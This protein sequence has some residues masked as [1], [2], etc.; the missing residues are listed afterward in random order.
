MTTTPPFGV[1]AGSARYAP[2][3]NPSEAV[4]LIDL[5]IYGLQCLRSLRRIEA[6]TQDTHRTQRTNF[7]LKFNHVEVVSDTVCKFKSFEASAD[8][9]K[10][11]IEQKAIKVAI[12]YE[13]Q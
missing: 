2:S 4:S 3:V 1:P 9:Y 13:K 6:A 7:G 12:V 8:A 11:L 5:P 10:R